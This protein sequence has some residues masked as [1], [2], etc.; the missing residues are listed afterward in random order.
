MEKWLYPE[1][2]G[3]IPFVIN[4]YQDM[5]MKDI[6]A[7]VYSLPNNW[8]EIVTQNNGK[9]GKPSIHDIMIERND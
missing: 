7:N 9:D 4:I 3:G 5:C 1:D 2:L 6:C 8:K